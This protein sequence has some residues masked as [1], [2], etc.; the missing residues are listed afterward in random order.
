MTVSSVAA[1]MYTA[2]HLTFFTAFDGV[3]Y[4]RS[5]YMIHILGFV[6]VSSAVAVLYTAQRLLLV[7]AVAAAV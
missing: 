7:A 3:N 4:T 1:I 6:S 5:T 2:C